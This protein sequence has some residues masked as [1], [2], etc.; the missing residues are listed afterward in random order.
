MNYTHCFIHNLTPHTVTLLA[1]DGETVRWKFESR[2]VAR[3]AE[4]LT[5]LRPI[6]WD[7]FGDGG[8]SETIPAVSKCFG[9]VTGLP[10]M[11]DNVLYIVSQIVADACPWRYDL[12]VP[13]DVRRRNGEI[14]GCTGWSRPNWTDPEGPNMSD[15]TGGEG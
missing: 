7:P 2:G 9:P 1:S 11:K 10:D 5:T 15:N 12:I 6:A 4:E 14:I 13:H 8:M 3:C